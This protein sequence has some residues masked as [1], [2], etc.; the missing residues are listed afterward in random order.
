MDSHLK[1]Y[2][3]DHITYSNIW[4]A[5]STDVW[6]PMDFLKILTALWLE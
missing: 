5:I 1:G 4:Y 6:I 3:L 2:N